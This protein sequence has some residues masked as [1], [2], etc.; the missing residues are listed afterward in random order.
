MN[1]SGS[2]N[3][4]QA[5]D[6]KPGI[7]ARLSSHRDQISRQSLSYPGGRAEAV[8][9]DVAPMSL[10]DLLAPQPDCQRRPLSRSKPR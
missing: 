8:V 4:A 3:S 9:D 6:R 5:L 2:S 1:P 10:E 7:D